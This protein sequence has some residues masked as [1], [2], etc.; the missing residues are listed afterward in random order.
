MWTW[1]GWGAPVG[2]HMSRARRIS[3]ASL[4]PRLRRYG[5]C[6]DLLSGACDVIC[7]VFVFRVRRMFGYRTFS[8][9][10]DLSD[11]NYL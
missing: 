4:S 5:W 3:G 6:V 2:E 8:A 9:M 11:N 7:A 10:S 1:E